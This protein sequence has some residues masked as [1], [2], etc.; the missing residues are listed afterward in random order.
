MAKRIAVLLCLFLFGVGILPFSGLA[1]E[2]KTVRVGWYE[3]PFNHTDSSGRKSGYAYEYQ[4]KIAAY[5]GWRY[6]YVEGSWPELLQMLIDGDIDLLSDVS[7]TEERTETMLFSSLPMGAEEY[8]VFV[9][10]DNEEITK[11]DYSTFNGKKAG[12]N[13]GSIQAD[14]FRAWAEENGVQV[15]VV[16]MMESVDESIAIL[17]RGGIDMYVMLD[18]YYDT[19]NAVP[20]CKIGSSDFFF[21]VS[22]SRPELL[23]DL[24]AAMSKIQ[25]ENRFYNQQLYAKYLRT[26]GAN[27]YLTAEEKAWLSA[28]ETI[29]VGYQDNYL[30]FCAKDPATGELTGAL[31]DYLASAADCLENAHLSFEAIAY[32]S[33]AAALEALKNGEVDCIF[34]SSLTD[35]DGETLGVFITPALIRT[36]VDVLVHSSEQK[37]FVQR[38]QVTV[39]VIQGSTNDEMLLLEYFPHWQAV[40]FPDTEACIEAVANLRADCMLISNYRFNNIAK[41]CDKY[42]L[43]SLSTGVEMDCCFAVSRENSALYSILTKIIG[44]VPAS[45][46]NAALSYYFT[47]DAKT[48]LGDF[49]RDNL[50]DVLLVIAG[51]AVLILFLL[52]QSIRAMRKAKDG[53]KLIK[54][55]ETD[56]LTGLYNENF[57]FEYVGRLYREDPEKPMDAIVLNIDQFH[58]VNEMKGRPY[59]D[60]VLRTLG[61]EIQTHLLAMGGIAARSEGDHFSVYCPHQDDYEAAFRHLQGK[62]NHLSTNTNIQLRMG[63]SHGEAET[64]PA[65]L[66]E[67]AKTACGMARGRVQEHLVVFNE[68]IRERERFDQ[69][70]LDDLPGALEK[71]EF[72][73]YYQPKYDIQFEPP[74]LNSAEALVRWQHPE[75]GIIAPNDF[76]PLFERNGKIND[77]DKYVLR[78]A[79]RQIARWRD[80]YGVVIPVSVNLSRLDVFDPTLEAT[81]E[82]LLAENGLEP[83]AL[84]LEVTESAY[85]KNADQVTQVIEG[86]R[87]KGYEIEMDDFGSGYSALNMLSSMPIDVL[88]MDREFIRNI[89]RDDKNVQLVQ[90]IRDIAK[91]LRVPV[92][93]EGVETEGQMALLRELGCALVQGYYFSRPVPSG[94]FEK[95]IERVIQ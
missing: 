79:A 29:R 74:K 66:F 4:Q 87:K 68:K 49:V 70:L 37:S 21:A 93:A 45:T 11:E 69:R 75:L 33:A 92:I 35:Y 56:E 90:L 61:E 88:K 32:P 16:E 94:D 25:D 62:L 42:R 2:T 77:L 5:S 6:E 76:I 17:N 12:V 38:E 57:F 64:E 72:H 3:S 30:A 13:Q 27:L 86:L 52:F 59:G 36:D 60:M 46:V 22:K 91:N 23:S 31:K 34:P 54:A 7:Y 44:V 53:Q 15:E 8:Y 84:K 41:L 89:D 47:E 85:V 28:H 14:L 82:N 65:L 48:G 10:P 58:S 55:M 95:L 83:S 18:A 81:L 20:V 40:Y 26:T 43:I 39:A 1:A 9:A 78:E 71:Q 19:S 50:A 24:N 63:V 67:Q 80:T 51:V 73:L